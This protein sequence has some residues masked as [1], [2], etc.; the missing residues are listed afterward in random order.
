MVC[1]IDDREDVWNFAPNLVTVKP[2][3]Y[4]AG[5]GDI[6]DPLAN[7]KNSDEAE[8]SKAKGAS[9]NALELSLD[10]N[11]KAREVTAKLSANEGETSTRDRSQSSEGDQTPN[12]ANERG[13]G[14]HD[15]LSSDS[16]E[17]QDEVTAGK[18]QSGGMYDSCKCDQQCF[19]YVNKYQ[20]IEAL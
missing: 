7:K 2:Y 13:A 1:I 10:G 19:Y 12:E 20:L 8:V 11:K 9:Q 18:S 5:T 16:E 17:N 3:R 6:N 15:E 14:K 4:F